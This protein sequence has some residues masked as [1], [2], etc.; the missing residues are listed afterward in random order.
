MDITSVCKRY[1]KQCLEGLQVALQP[2][3]GKASE[4][5]SCMGKH[6]AILGSFLSKNKVDGCNFVERETWLVWCN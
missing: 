2:L 4:C 1:F 3:A 5:Q 6:L